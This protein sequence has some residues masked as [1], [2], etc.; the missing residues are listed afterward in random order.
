M[1]RPKVYATPAERTAAYRARR[2]AQ[3]AP[4]ARS[5]SPGYT[6]WRKAIQEARALLSATYEELG[7]WMTERSERWHES[8]RGGDLEADKD[9]LYEILDGLDELSI[10]GK[11]S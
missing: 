8:D 4:G 5:A 7:D 11:A 1:G 2:A 6:K 3:D 9:R 10:R